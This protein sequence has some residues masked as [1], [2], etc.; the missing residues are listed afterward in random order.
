MLIL[1]QF[2]QLCNSISRFIFNHW[3]PLFCFWSLKGGPPLLIL[4]Q[5]PQL[6]NSISR[7]IFNHWDPLF[8]FWSLKGG[9]PLLILRQFH[10]GATWSHLKATLPSIQGFRIFYDLIFCCLMHILPPKSR[11]A[12]YKSLNVYTQ[13]YYMDPVGAAYPE[14]K[15]RLSSGCFSETS[16]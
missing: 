7:F 13:W 2:P 1:R 8:C 14:K 15:E 4:R 12:A 5:F 11:P 16:S 6:C 10:H 3:D 9:P